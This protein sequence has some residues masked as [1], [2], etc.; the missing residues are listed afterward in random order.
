MSTRPLHLAIGFVDWH[1]AVVASGAELRSKRPDAAAR[2]ALEHV[3]RLVSDYLVTSAGGSRFRVRLRLYTGWHDGTT[4]T[5]RFQGI[6]KVKRTYASQVRTYRGGRVAFLGG[7]D[8]VQLGA[9]LAYASPGRL[10]Q[11]H[12][13]HLL[14]TLRDRDGRP[15]EKMVDTA[16]V[17]DLLGLAH[18]NE[19]QRYVVVSDDDDMLPGVFAAEAAGA[20]VGMLS[21]PGKRSRFMSHAAD[22]ISTYG[23]SEHEGHEGHSA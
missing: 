3:E 9:R 16:L 4:R 12:A 23:A 8:G 1:T 5:P 17:V 11:K 18:R 7:D 21:R 20:S 13:V 6:T 22:L 19:A 2:T 10:L 15:T 14:D